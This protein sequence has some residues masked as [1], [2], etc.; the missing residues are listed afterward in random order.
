MILYGSW[1]AQPLTLRHKIAAQFNI[2]KTGP[3]EVVAN[4][5]TRDGYNLKDIESAL[6]IEALQAY[7]SSTET[8]HVKLWNMTLDKI[9]G[10]TPVVVDNFVVLK[11]IDEKIAGMTEEEYKI[12]TTAKLTDGNGVVHEVQMGPATKKEYLKKN[13]KKIK[14]TK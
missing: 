10:K 5:V 9:E 1:I 13:A 8:D 14:K 11:P 12:Y 3:T 2:K 7:L 6:T 4:E